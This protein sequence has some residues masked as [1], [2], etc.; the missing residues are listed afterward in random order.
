MRTSIVTVMESRSGTGPRIGSAADY[1]SSYS[2]AAPVGAWP[3]E[4][5]WQSYGDSQLDALIREA[6]ADRRTSLSPKL[7]CVALKP[8]P[9]T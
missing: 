6:L 5:W 7:V 3:T 8:R 4:S 9:R 2:L 1:A